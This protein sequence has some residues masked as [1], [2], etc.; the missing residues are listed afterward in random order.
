MYW[1]SATQKFGL[2]IEEWICSQLQERGYPARL[3]SN[4]FENVDIMIGDLPVEVRAARCYPRKIRPGVYGTR[5]QFDL[6]RG[7]NPALVD[8]VAIL[9]ATDGFDRYPF[10]IP[11]A[12]TLARSSA[13]ITSHP[14]LYKGW[15]AAG[16]NNWGVID[17]MLESR[18]RLAGLQM[19][20]F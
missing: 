19:R 4:F 11:G 20:M 7:L 8:Y 16:L 2:S 15:L 12:W 3:V 13:S 6:T 1:M 9:V 14:T 10:I 17:T 5:W 18:R